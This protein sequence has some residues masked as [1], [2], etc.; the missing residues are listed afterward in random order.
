[1][2]EGVADS[3]CRCLAVIQ[4]KA[5]STI[6]RLAADVPKIVDFIS[7]FSRG[8]HE[9]AFRSKDGL[10]FGYFLKTETPQ[11]LQAEFDKCEG[12]QSGDSFL[13]VEAGHLIAGLGFTR[14]WTW[15]Q[16]H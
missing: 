7:R 9:L 8:E 14:A 2:E 10:L 4:L 16:H 1:M 11:F 15:L 12:T 3:A 13:V 5:D 6:Q